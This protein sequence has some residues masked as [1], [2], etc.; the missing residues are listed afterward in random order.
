MMKSKCEP[1]RA[2]RHWKRITESNG[3]ELI[4]ASLPPPPPPPEQADPDP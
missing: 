1:S 2:L 3:G 4:N